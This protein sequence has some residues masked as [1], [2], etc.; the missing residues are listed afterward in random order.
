M[1]GS[2]GTSYDPQKGFI[3]HIHH[4]GIFWGRYMVKIWSIIYGRWYP[5]Y[6]MVYGGPCLDLQSTQNKAHVPFL[7]GIKAIISGTLEL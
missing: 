7:L 4:I 6:L 1:D 2:F 3:V 5:L